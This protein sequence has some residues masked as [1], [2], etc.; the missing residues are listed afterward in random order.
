MILVVIQ[1]PLGVIEWHLGKDG[2][3]RCYG[4]DLEG[5]NLD[6]TL[7]GVITKKLLPSA[8]EKFRH[9][10]L[11][12]NYFAHL[13]GKPLNMPVLNA[14]T[15]LMAIAVRGDEEWVVWMLAQGAQIDLVDV[16]G[17]DALYFA[18]SVGNIATTRALLAAGAKV[19][20]NLLHQVIMETMT[21][22]YGIVSRLE[23]NGY[24]TRLYEEVALEII[25]LLCGAG[26]KKDTVMTL[27]LKE[28]TKYRLS[29][30]AS[31]LARAA[32]LHKIANY[33]E[34]LG[35]TAAAA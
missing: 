8:L 33:L 3:T 30:T 6:T 15:P 34:G 5:K 24:N 19:H 13:Y 9:S 16:A 2:R 20:T 22:G 1:T 18:A 28:V 4:R 14:S 25:K 32:K 17:F 23:L 31:Q 29:Y 12:F 7:H 35:I 10:T 26:A 21:I 27:H 11:G